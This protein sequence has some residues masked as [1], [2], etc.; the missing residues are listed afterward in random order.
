M[1]LAITQQGLPWPSS[2]EAQTAPS[3]SPEQFPQSP[4][5]T[6]PAIRC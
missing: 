4:S 5:P 3:C 6:P 1:C 2:R